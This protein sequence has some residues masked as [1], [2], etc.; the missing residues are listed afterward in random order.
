LAEKIGADPRLACSI[1]C[2]LSSLDR[3]AFA[4]RCSPAQFAAFLQKPVSEL[5][6]LAAV[7]QAVGN[8]EV[9]V[10]APPAAA[11]APVAADSRSL[12][13]LLAEDTAAN[14]KLV[15]AILKKRGH[16]VGVVHN[17]REALDML[18]H[19]DFD[20]ILMDVQMPI[21]DGLQATAAIRMLTKP[22]QS[23]IPIIA[24]TAHTMPGDKERCL[25]AGMD[26]YLSKPINS[27]ELLEM[28]EFAMRIGENRARSGISAP[29]PALTSVS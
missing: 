6:L 26:A 18:K 2:M 19:R 24:M 28:L 8:L 15:T 3:Q 16:E 22:S 25:A 29:R 5:E 14:Q 1:I 13:I 7:R 27:K 10:P 21:M 12:R 9:Q 23:Q 11:R 20:L 4:D 17:G